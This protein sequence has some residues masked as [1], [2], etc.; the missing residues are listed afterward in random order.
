MGGTG[1]VLVLLAAIVA[2]GCGG[3]GDAAGRQTATATPS[4][5]PSA[6]PTRTATPEREAAVSR[7]RGVR[8]QR[9]GSFASPVF[10]T[11]PP[12]DRSRV[13]VVEQDGR[14][15]VMRGGKVLDAPFLDIRGLVT[16]G[17][18]QGLLSLAFAPD[19]AESGRFY[20]YYTDRSQDQRVVEYRAASPDR[21]DAGS[22]RLLLRMADN[23]VNHNGG[24]LAFGPDGLLYIGTG[25][26]GGGGD[27]HGSRGNAQDLGSLLGKI[28]RID[29]RAAGGDAY[30]VPA[31]NPFASRAG[32]RGEIY[33]YGLRNPWRFSFD[34]ET[35]ALAIGDVGQGEHEEINYVRRGGGKGA[36]FGWR[37]FEGRARYTPGER[38]AGHVEP[39]I[40]QS[41]ARGNCSI[42]GG[43]WV[44]DPAV[45]LRG[46]YVFGDFCKGRI[47]KA[48]LTGGKARSVKPTALHVDGLSSF[49]E[50]ARGR[51][52]VASLDGPV[53]RIAPK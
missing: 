37:P 30:S 49:G 31:A 5:A 25:D 2:V 26:G 1:V 51:V 19:Y 52:Y 44:R 47:Y 45:S 33:A 16:G 20:V 6:D 34:R 36:N 10:V 3:G 21:A 14:I 12:G 32:A 38:A 42:T 24:Q 9:V 17:G 7:A 29:P 35:G 40:V 48:K 4:P 39:V 22:A 41:H 15:R 23:E 8:L 50:D 28:L 11:A 27:R 18:E 43:V 46:R 13:M 53:Y